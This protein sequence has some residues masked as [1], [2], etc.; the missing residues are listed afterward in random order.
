MK[1]TENGETQS[2]QFQFIGKSKISFS[3]TFKRSEGG[4][5]HLPF[6]VVAFGNKAVVVYLLCFSVCIHF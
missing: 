6:F 2:K 4:N 1:T 5:I 3:H